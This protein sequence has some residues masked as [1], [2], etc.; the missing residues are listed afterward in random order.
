MVPKL[1]AKGS[2]FRGIGLYVLYD[3]W[4]AET[5]ERVEWFET[6]NLATE[7]GHLAWRL[8]AA[9]AM[10]ADRLKQRAG[11]SNAGRKSKDA[12]LHLTLSWHPEEAEGL[13]RHEMV[14]AAEGA[15]KALRAEDRQV[16]IVA[17]NDEEQPHVHVVI[18][19]VCPREG[20]MLS[21]SKEKLHLSRWAQRYEEERGTIYCEERVL[22]NAARDR[23]EYTRGGKD[24]P[25]HLYEQRA[26]NDRGPR[27]GR[28]DTDRD[29]PNS[30]DP[31]SRGRDEDRRVGKEARAARRRQ[32]EAW[33][34][35]AAD[36]RVRRAGLREHV[37]RDTAAKRQAVID[38]FRGRWRELHQRQR[39]E[40]AVFRED[41][42][43][44]LGRVNNRLR[45]LDLKG[46]IRGERRGRTLGAAFNTQVSAGARRLQLEADHARQRRRL[47]REQNGEVRRA[48]RR[49]REEAA[50]ALTQLR[51]R[52]Q[53]ERAELVLRASMEQA[54][55]RAAWRQRKRARAVAVE[56][57][58]R[59]DGATLSVSQDQASA[60]QA[61]L[62]KR[63]RRRIAKRQQRRPDRGRGR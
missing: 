51:G 29:Q 49:V 39:D 8:M 61:A 25:R 40:L 35:L 46:V 13:D 63:L 32:S 62:H 31:S 11:V 7:D 38:Q 57:R 60:S 44:V 59:R 48:I 26:A 2:S 33:L 14:R 56:D 10:D 47:E 12:V 34:K 21:S 20:R 5:D 37:K 27:K 55:V 36:D 1:H 23:G 18:N 58:R 15:I 16:L 4:R 53:A 54:K 50:K 52:F 9:T 30:G 3:K 19:R 42:A 6:R 43:S 24:V 41:E 45:S 17:H 28:A 22:N